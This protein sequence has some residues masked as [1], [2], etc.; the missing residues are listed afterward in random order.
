MNLPP[1]IVIA[2]TASGVGKTTIS[3]ALMAALRRRGRRVQPFKIG[4]DFIDP[5]LHSVAAGRTGRNLDG[6]M[7]TPEMN[8]SIFAEAVTDADIAVIE[9]VMGLFD[10]RDARSEAGSTAEM[11]KMLGAPVVLV[12]DAA[13]MAR[14]AAAVVRGFE[15]FDPDLNLA[16][17]LFNRVGGEGHYAYLRD[18][19]SGYCRAVPLGWLERDAAVEIGER[20]LGLKMGR[21]ALSESLLDA[22]ADWLERHVDVDGLFNLA[23]AVPTGQPIDIQPVTGPRTRIGVARDAAFCFYYPDNLDLLARFGA[24]IV[25]FSPMNDASLP[26]NLHGLYFGG[27]Y[28]ELHAEKLSANRPLREEIRRFIAADRPVYA[29][30]GGFMY[31]T[32][33]IVDTD[34]REFP[35]VGVFPT[36][37][38]MQSRLAALGYAEVEVHPGAAW[39][40][41]GLTVRGHEFHYSAM[42]PLAETVRRGYAVMK[43]GETR[44]EGFCIRRALASYIHLHFRSCPAFAGQFVTACAD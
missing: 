26:E 22:L 42:A 3:M 15:D 39:V 4:P 23:G 1:A 10:G 5:S 24:E 19:V 27:G 9:G 8:R 6:W 43:N 41:S 29:E 13:A 30:C 14:S 44:A 2:G 28:P 33:A 32:E 20:H 38:V 17:V 37:T 11:A 25:E 31:L 18:A 36:R 21:E 35:M 16:G 34:G 7:L 40:Q 12:V